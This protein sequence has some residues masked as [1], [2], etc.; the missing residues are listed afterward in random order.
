MTLDL[1]M[2]RATVRIRGSG[3]QGTGFLLSVLSETYTEI[4]HTY[5][6]TAHHII[7]KQP[8]ITVQ[9]SDPFSDELYAPIRLS[10][11]RQPI[12]KVDV[13][14]APLRDDP[15]HPCAPLELETDF[16]PA[17][18][19]IPWVRLGADIHYIEILGP[20]DRP[21]VRSGNIGAIDQKGIDHP[22]GYRYRA[23]LVDCRSYDGFSGSPCYLDAILPGLRPEEL[24][25]H[26][27]LTAH[28]PP[29]GTM[30]H[31]AP[32]C[33]MFTQH[34]TDKG[35]PTGVASRYG[36]GVM[37]P[38]NGI[39]RALMTD[40]MRRHRR[41]RDERIVGKVDAG[42]KF[43]NVSSDAPNESENEFNRFEDLTR[44]LV[45]TP[46]SEVE[47]RRKDKS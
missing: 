41:K 46:K 38:A 10:D 18:P 37:L 1:S 47:T 32:F 25:P 3:K 31:I 15:D 24:P 20:L 23:H 12:E 2:V 11:W 21:M 36:V 39:R 17:D 43:E 7:D 22:D 34:L 26:R 9:I 13:A 4:R 19:P 27:A 14:F 5:V 6:V 40:E 30:Y 29:M 42:P 16:V 45:N 44:K 28:L 8:R 35:K 33:G